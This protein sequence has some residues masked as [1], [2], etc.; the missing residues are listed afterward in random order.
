MGTKVGLRRIETDLLLI[1][2]KEIH[3]VRAASLQKFQNDK[4]EQHC[5]VMFQ[6]TKEKS[7][8]STKVQNMTF[9]IPRT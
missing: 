4:V 8:I 2:V 9:F 6:N 5:C 7:C 1:S 3:G